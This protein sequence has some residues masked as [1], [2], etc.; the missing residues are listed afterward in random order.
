MGE[1]RHRLTVGANR[2]TRDQRGSVEGERLR[3]PPTASGVV[4][5]LAGMV[6]IRDP[7]E[8]DLGT[9]QHH[10]ERVVRGTVANRGD[11][12][13]FTRERQ[14]GLQQRAQDVHRRVVPTG[15]HDP[16]LLAAQLDFQP[17]RQRAEPVEELLVQRRSLH[18]LFE[19]RPVLLELVV[20]VG[21]A[22]LAREIRSRCRPG[23]SVVLVIADHHQRRAGVHHRPR[24][25]HRRDLVRAPIDEVADENRLPFR[26]TPMAMLVAVA[27]LAQQTFERMDVSVHIA[28]HVVALDGLLIHSSPGFDVIGRSTS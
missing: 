27:H 14:V 15:V 12:D 13:R 3:I 18:H 5:G 2:V 25:L 8:P 6:E 11:L 9:L 7:L 17:Q 21:A 26:V 1:W 28:D 10:F 19:E 4:A 23:D 16:Q 20:A 22:E 24:E